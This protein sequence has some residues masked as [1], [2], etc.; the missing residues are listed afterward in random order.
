[1]PIAF[2]AFLLESR[3]GLTVSSMFAGKKAGREERFWQVVC[4]R[5]SF[6]HFLLESRKEEVKEGGVYTGTDRQNGK[7]SMNRVQ[8]F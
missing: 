5:N 2:P 4:F 3:K 8:H 7:L 6:Q 1:M